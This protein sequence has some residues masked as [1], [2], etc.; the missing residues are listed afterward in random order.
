MVLAEF[1]NSF[2]NSWLFYPTL[3]VAS[4]ALG[5]VFF[6]MFV[7]PKEDQVEEKALKE[8]V[9]G[10]VDELVEL[11]GGD[12]KK[13]ISYGITPIG[14]VKKAWSFEEKL[15]I[16]DKNF[17]P[18]RDDHIK[19]QGTSIEKN[20]YYYFKIRPEGWITRLFANLT[21]DIL[22]M[23]SHTDYII[24]QQEQV[25]DGEILSIADNWNPVKVAGVWIPDSQ[26]G[27]EIIKEKTGWAMFE[28]TLETAE[29]SIR[30]VNYMNLKFAQNI[31]E[32]QK[33]EELM[34]QRYGSK[35]AEMVNEK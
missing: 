11:F 28:D 24:V 21:D 32:I 27:A 14:M 10:E 15:E 33:K 23:D 17:N 26:K 13:K 4:A 25:S 22:N 2:L 35:A 6:K 9:Q 8:I 16:D 30:S 29:T 31:E 7:D 12:L 20:S 18:E 19:E 3:V 34:Q 1:V 5:V